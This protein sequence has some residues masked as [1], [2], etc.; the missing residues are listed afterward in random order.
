MQLNRRDSLAVGHC[1]ASFLSPWCSAEPEKPQDCDDDD[2]G[3]DDVDDVVHGSTFACVKEPNRVVIA[4]HQTLM[5]TVS[6][7]A[8]TVGTPAHLRS[9]GWTRREGRNH[10]QQNRVS[11]A[12]IGT[13]NGPGH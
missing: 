13:W 6:V 5:W 12:H 7:S 9:A 10:K 1:T 2:D 3:A 11:V 8:R 4:I